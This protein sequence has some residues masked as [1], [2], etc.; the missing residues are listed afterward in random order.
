MD[1]GEQPDFPLLGLARGPGF[2]VGL[3]ITEQS[4]WTGAIL[5]GKKSASQAMEYQ[6]QAASG[7]TINNRSLL[8][9]GRW[10]KVGVGPPLQQG[11]VRE[12]FKGP[13]KNSP[14]HPLYVGDF[15]LRPPIAT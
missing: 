6:K 10:R 15:T 3:V 9:G 4:I 12:E 14:V 7:R 1:I 8:V 13:C 11:T 2:P 5:L